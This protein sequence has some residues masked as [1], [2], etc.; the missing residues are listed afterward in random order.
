MR[1]PTDLFRFTINSLDPRL[2]FAD[3]GIRGIEAWEPNFGMSGPLVKGRVWFA[4]GIDYRWER[5]SFDTNAGTEESRYQAALSW[6]AVDAALSPSHH[7][8]FWVSTDPQTTHHAFITAFTPG[9]TL[10]QLHNGGWRSATIDRMVL[11]ESS[12]LETAV[13]IGA[14]RT[15]VTPS[16]SLP[17]VLAHD[18]LRGNYFNTQERMAHRFE[19]T[20]QWS[21]SMPTHAG[22]HLV[23]AGGRFSSIAYDGIDAS[24][25]V[26][27]LR[28]D[29]SLARRISFFGPVAV[30][31]SGREMSLFVQDTWAINADL[32][33][34]VGVRYDEATIARGAVAAP[35]IAASWK[36][37]Q[38][39]T[40]VGGFGQYSDKVLLAS[41][42]FPSL[43]SRTV[44]EFDTRGLVTDGPRTYV[45]RLDG[46]LRMP[47]ADAWHLQLD[48]RAANGFIYRV[49]YQEQHGQQ[50]PV[51]DV[52]DEPGAEAL[53]LRSAGTSRS[54]SLEATVG[55]QSTVN[56][57]SVYMSYVR[58]SAIGNL[59]DFVSL[60][61]S[62]K[63]PYVQAD[64]PGPL[65]AD[66]PHRFLAWGLLKLPS[67]VTVAP[68]LELRNGFPFSAIDEEW[69][70]AGSRNGQRFPV[71]ASL[72]LSVNKIMKLPGSLPMAKV[73]LK[74][75]NITG[76]H[77]SRD[78]Q[79]DLLRPDFGTLYNPL[80]RQIRGV[81]EI[82][83]GKT[84]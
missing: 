81:F 21:R 61:G 35:R 28:S 31:Q 1:V 4:Q 72:D 18:L 29:S 37:D 40:L 33:L 36:I 2:H 6:N 46:D 66:V 44:T 48:R 57:S 30:S 63:E 42:T 9:S 59:N 54:R 22:S 70:F 60:E 71:F 84:R 7:I 41:A 34:D 39:L 32:T 49:A 23:K 38:A 52:D 79:R 82:L 56:G 73:G 12:T 78:V 19:I 15:E 67:R 3:G 45:N 16:G 20:S 50:E 65:A 47:N 80:R 55:Q 51:L 17:Y 14:L 25:P 62:V 43:Q 5:F 24:M 68:F 13:Q 77:N 83:W 53:V 27:Q 8:S 74:L 64:A 76:S 26:E 75:Y 69:R 11:S 10:P 58:A